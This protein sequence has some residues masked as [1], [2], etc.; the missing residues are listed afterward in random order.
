MTQGGTVRYHVPVM[1][2]EV[3]EALLEGPEGPLVDGTAGG[4]GHIAALDEAAR[5]Q[6]PLIGVDR[7][8]DALARCSQRFS[9]RPHVVVVRGNFG[10]LPRALAKG[11]FEE[12]NSIAGI[13]LDLG[14]SS[15]QLDHGPRGFAFRFE[16]APLDMR[17]DAT[18]DGTRTARQLL[19][20]LTE[21]ALCDVL[22]GYGEVKHARAVAKRIKQAVSAGQMTTTG[23]L[24]AAVGGRRVKGRAHPATT[25]FQALRIAVNR[26]LEALDA[27]LSIAPRLLKP[28]GRLAVIAYHSLEDR[29]VKR[30]F[31]LGEAGPP[32]PGHLPPPSDWTQTWRRVTRK[33]L[34][35]S[36]KEIAL[37]PRARSAK[38]RVAAFVHGREAHA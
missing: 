15:W 4:G 35:P 1:V 34:V 20:E 38:M 10:D 22:R 2:D 24:V 16:D 18:D 5:G 13:L 17:M 33:A 31:K 32:R 30:T 26:E 8:P 21:D 3:V 6:R 7:D 36:A 9:K 14:V 37:N 29:R 12:P 19:E 11:G 28:G 27:A 25:V 23:D